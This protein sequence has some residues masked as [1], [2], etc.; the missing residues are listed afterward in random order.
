M[1]VVRKI[2]GF[3]LNFQHGIKYNLSMSFYIHHA[4]V[5]YSLMKVDNITLLYDG[6]ENNEDYLTKNSEK[7]MRYIYYKMI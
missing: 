6:L 2:S 4:Y 5:D 3:K 1:E 7:I